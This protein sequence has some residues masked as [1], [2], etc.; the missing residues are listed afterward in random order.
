MNRDEAL[1]ITEQSLKDLNE[2][3]KSGKSGALCSYLDALSVFPHY[4]YRN[5]FLIVKQKPTATQVA[6]FRAWRK[7]GRWVKAGEKGIGIIAPLAIRAKP[8]NDED[9]VFGFR[10]VH[11]FDASQTEGEPLPDISQAKGNPTKALHALECLFAKLGIYLESTSLPE[12]WPW[13]LTW[14]S[15]P[16]C[17]SAINGNPIPD[18]CP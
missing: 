3:L 12:G 14:R 8:E 16:S 10:V 1:E 11:V 5:I 17:R 15:S 18:A 13:K 2:S 7:L 4:S 6:G 9:S